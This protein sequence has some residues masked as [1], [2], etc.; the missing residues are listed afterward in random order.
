MMISWS[1]NFMFYLMT[2]NVLV[3]LM[4]YLII[5]LQLFLA[6]EVVPIHPRSCSQN[7]KINKSNDYFKAE[8]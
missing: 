3:I 1:Q 8:H 5:Y 6:I 4:T 7:L 2:N